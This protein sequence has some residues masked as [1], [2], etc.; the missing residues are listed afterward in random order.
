MYRKENHRRIFG[1]TAMK[2][3]INALGATMG[4]AMR[5]L[6]NFL[7]E[8]SRQDSVGEY[9][10]LVRESF[11][12]M[13]LPDN[14]RLER[15]SDDQAS[16]WIKR[17]V[18]DVLVL[19]VRLKRDKF[20]AIVSLTNFG[21]IWS[22]VPHILFQRNSLYYCKYYLSRIK[23]KEKA[24]TLLRR[25]L[26][27]E[28]MKRADLIVTPSDAMTEMI[29]ETCPEVRNRKFRTLYHGFEKKSLSEPLD[30]KYKA[31]LKTDGYKFLYPTH[32]QKHKGFEVLF[33]ML[34]VL[35]FEGMKFT[36]FAPVSQE[37]WP[38]KKYQYK[39]KIDKLSLSNHIVFMGHIPQEQMGML[40]RQSDLM[41]YPS[42]CES[43]GFS[44]IEAMGHDLPIVAADT[45]VN[46]EICG[47]GA[48]YYS[49]LDHQAGAEAVKTA[50]G[51][52]S[53]K[54]LSEAGR[55]RVNS[56][57][58]SWKRYVSEFIEITKEVI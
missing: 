5:H 56:F 15:L 17:I 34:A 38:V 49:P 32:P 30:N 43:F 58:W 33:N 53:R 11:P 27:V 18:G 46:R 20:N 39:Q 57:D 2:V 25:R 9:I 12:T 3:L 47:E 29:R 21:P 13:Q 54:R 24:E 40:Y 4:G 45:A 14:L 55:G 19:P 1:V 10:V 6:T 51:A 16:G 50:L 37:D 44:M 48:I 8:L 41:I 42:L 52:D 36:L 26:V 35:K 31:M 7:P 23:G 22:P 28:S